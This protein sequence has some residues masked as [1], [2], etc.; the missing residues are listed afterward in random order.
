VATFEPDPA[1]ELP[2]EYL[3]LC[4]LCR[5]RKLKVKELS[6]YL[7]HLHKYLKQAFPEISGRIKTGG[8][9]RYLSVLS[10]FPNSRD[11]REASPGEIAS[12]TYGKRDFKV[13]VKFAQELKE[14][15]ARSAASLS[16]P[17]IGFALRSV[18]ANVVRLRGE[19]AALEDKIAELYDACPAT[20]LITIPGIGGLLAAVIESEIKRIGRFPS[21]KH[22]TG[23]VGAFPELK[24]SG[25]SA[26]PKPKMTKKGNRYLNQA[27]YLGV[28][29]AISPKASD[30][31]IKHFYW[32]QVAE[33]KERMVAL[34][35]AMRK[36]THII[37]GVLISGKV[38]DSCFEYPDGSFE[39]RFVDR[40]RGCF[41]PEEDISLCETIVPIRYKRATAPKPQKA[42]DRGRVALN[43]Q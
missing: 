20:P 30:N 2:E 13:G 7:N 14:L 21:A 3:D 25:D 12:L 15:A 22:L 24:E 38:Y 42:K 37:Y 43:Q 26:L 40:E 27:V 33:G 6:R 1:P 28:L 29:A 36:L 8:G 10:Y 35:S 17:G 4:E 31:T 9:L 32:S 19:I 16:G 11:I 18:A 5:Y 34:G 39:V 23:Y 41:I